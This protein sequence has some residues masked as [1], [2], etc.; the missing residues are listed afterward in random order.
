MSEK[1]KNASGERDCNLT[2]EIFFSEE[3][4][5]FIQGNKISLVR[6]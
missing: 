2:R 3:N 4:E 1:I 5:G 6:D